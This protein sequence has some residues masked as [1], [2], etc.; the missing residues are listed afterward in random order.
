MN[1]QFDP[2]YFGSAGFT[3]PH[4]NSSAFLGPR[5]LD[6]LLRNPGDKKRLNF[7]IAGLGDS[8]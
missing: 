8:S 6:G 7:K 3:I 1:L 5:S 2:G 4:P